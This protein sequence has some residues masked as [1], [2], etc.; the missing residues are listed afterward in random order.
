MR[1]PTKESRIR[2]GCGGHHPIQQPP[3][4]FF[5]EIPSYSRGSSPSRPLFLFPSSSSHWDYPAPVQSFSAFQRVPQ[6]YSSPTQYFSQ[7]IPVFMSLPGDE[8]TP[9]ESLFHGLVHNYIRFETLSCPRAGNTGKTQYHI[10]RRSF[11][12]FKGSYSLLGK[13]G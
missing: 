11:F 13:L 10:K 2:R 5:R 8:R 3:L 7:L 9:L 4:S 6:F 12:Y 1:R